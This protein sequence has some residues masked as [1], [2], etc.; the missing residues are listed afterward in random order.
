MDSMGYDVEPTFGKSM[1]NAILSGLASKAAGGDFVQGAMSA[2]VVW[3]YNDFMTQEEF[4]R[5]QSIINQNVKRT[6]DERKQLIINAKKDFELKAKK[7]NDIATNSARFA[8]VSAAIA[9]S[10]DDSWAAAGAG[11]ATLVSVMA[12]GA[13]HL[14]LGLA[15]KFKLEDA[16]WDAAATKINFVEINPV[17]DPLLNEFYQEAVP[18]TIEYMDNSK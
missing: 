9:A 16:I 7:M 12:T 2:M 18:A 8:A 11:V 13:K 10:E 15:S 17:I 1:I 6:E 5:M 4:K 14:F 3:L